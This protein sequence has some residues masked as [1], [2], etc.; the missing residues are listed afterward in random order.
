MTAFTESD[1]TYMREALRLAAAAGDAAEVPVGAV[2]VHDD[3][4]I[5]VGSNAPIATQDASAHAEILALRDAGARSGNYRFP[6][7]RLFV[8]LEP[9]MMCAGAL[10]HARVAEVIFAASDPKSGVAGG[11]TDLSAGHWLNHQVRYRGG[12]L[13]GDAAQLL[14]GFFKARR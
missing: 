5:G 10:V 8:T 3:N 1:K 13:R 9:C 7:S 4:I 11:A 14:V 2:L 12:L 6:G